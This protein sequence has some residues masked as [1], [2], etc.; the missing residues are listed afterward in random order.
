MANFIA[1]C[2]T[3]CSKCP[4]FNVNLKS[5]ED[6]KRCSS[7]WEKYLG[8][9]LKPEKL[10]SCDGCSIPD[11][12][13]KYYY[14]NCRVRKCAELNGVKNCAHCSAYPC[15][16]VRTIH[17]IQEPDARENIET[18]IGN[19]IPRKDYLAFIEPYEGIKHLDEIRK[20]LRSDE[21][22]EMIPV[23]KKST[24]IPFPE[25]I[26]SGKKEKVAYQKIHAII[27]SIETDEN[28]SYAR[29]FELNKNRKQ[30]I[31]LLWA[32]G[33]YGETEKGENSAIL[34]SEKYSE[35]KITTYYSKIQEYT[36]ILERF[37][38]ECEIIPLD[39]KTWKTAGGALR[40]KGWCLKITLGKEMPEGFLKALM[41]YS[42]LLYEKHGEKAFR[43]FTQADMRNLN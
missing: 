6:R 3:D 29:S 28:V 22:I 1:K 31:K 37:G 16:D 25:K 27:S 2:G 5:I 35:Q 11:K 10:R 26:L 43:Y 23:S 12:K 13:R 39:I 4:S 40:K 14:I 41:Y 17:N 38:L 9:R 32:F 42:K 24:T 15:Q 34:N 18:R 36:Y 20:M 30:L 33:L 7:G 19:K 21:I 8:I